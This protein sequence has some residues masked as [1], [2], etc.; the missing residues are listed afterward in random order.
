M[1]MSRHRF[2]CIPEILA[3]VWLITQGIVPWLDIKH[4]KD[5]IYKYESADVYWMGLLCVYMYTCVWMY[6]WMYV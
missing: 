2:K 5:C 4:G 6:I 1:N 3:R